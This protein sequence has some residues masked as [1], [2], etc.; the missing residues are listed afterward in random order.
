L[1]TT[2]CSSQTRTPELPQRFDSVVA[3][4]LIEHLENPEL[5]LKRYAAHLKPDGRI[6][7][8]TPYPF[9]LPNFTYALLR[10]PRTCTNPEHVMWF[11]PSTLHALS[12]RAGLDVRHWEVIEDYYPGGPLAY[13]I[14]VRLISTLRSVLPRRL[15]CNSILFVLSRAET[16]HQP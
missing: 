5:F 11:C 4:E 10:F 12:K 1:V 14:L 15:R 3:G 16:S 7:L 9:C 2:T 6:V 13:R 8:T